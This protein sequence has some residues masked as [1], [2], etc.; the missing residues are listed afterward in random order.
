MRSNIGL[1]TMTALG[2]LG[3]FFG[4]TQWHRSSMIVEQRLLNTANG[5]LR[6]PG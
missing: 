1:K 3:V 5:I 2:V 6:T 4:I